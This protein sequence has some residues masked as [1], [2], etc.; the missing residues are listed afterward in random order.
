MLLTH[1]IEMCNASTSALFGNGVSLIKNSANL[2]A[3]G[4]SS[5]IGSRQIL[6]NLLVAA[7]GSPFDAS[8]ITGIATYSLKS[9][10]LFSHQMFVVCCRAA[11]IKL[12]EGFPVR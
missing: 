6:A 3:S 8:S 12:D 5:R 1:A 2:F 10:F 11:F 7:S 9:F 4:V